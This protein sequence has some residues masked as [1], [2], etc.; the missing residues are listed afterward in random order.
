M[1][2]ELPKPPPAEKPK[3]ALA[4]A[5]EVKKVI[6]PVAA[7]T[8]VKPTAIILPPP[9]K[10][11][12]PKPELPPREERL[13]SK[14]AEPQTERELKT[15]PPAPPTPLPRE[16]V[17]SEI[18][19]LLRTPPPATLPE[20]LPAVVIDNRMARRRLT[21]FMSLAAGGLVV[22]LGYSL[23][24]IP[25]K[26][27]GLLVAMGGLISLVF[28]LRFGSLVAPPRKRPPAV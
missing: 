10:P 18:D 15:A 6:A 9:P 27:L 7:T 8:E 17:K 23:N 12:E 22:A 19:R 16:P 1:G 2:L 4:V 20:P 3:T 24:A 26:F 28:T 14:P 21:C 13:Q 11:V 25:L 5:V